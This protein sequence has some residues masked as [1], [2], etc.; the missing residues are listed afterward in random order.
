MIKAVIF[1]CFGVV[2][3]D[4][5]DAVYQSFG[6]DIVKDHDFIMDTLYAVNSGRI[7]S[8]ADAFS[9]HLGVDPKAWSAAIV[10][11]STLNEA[12]L[13]YIL[14]L[15]ASYKVA[16]LTNISKGGLGRIFEQ[17]F[18]DQYF[19][20]VVASGDI[21]YAK[22]EPEAYR[23][24]TK[25]LDVRFDESVFIDDRQDYI[26]GAQAV[27]MKT[28]VFKSNIQLKKDLAPLISN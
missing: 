8:T 12:L 22:P 11:G 24:V 26:D 19:D 3:I 16:M 18:L 25:R 9:K 20:T 21:G 10:K 2:R 6:G 5:F 15:R 1:D 14:D 17:G 23:E 28:I 13:S 27:G 4:A 7:G